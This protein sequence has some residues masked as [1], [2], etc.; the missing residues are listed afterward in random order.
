MN[1]DIEL[2]AHLMRRAGF[3]ASRTELEYRSSIGY[4]ATVEELLNPDTQLSSDRL[5][6]L[7]YHPH[8]WKPKHHQVWAGQVGY[9][10]W[11]APK[12]YYRRK[13]CYSGTKCS[14]LD[15]Q[16]STIIMKSYIR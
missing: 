13:W 15:T 16:K 10:T 3:G 1:N 2:I 6:F 11:L 14:L 7:R 12:E 9:M 5:E 8:F 4:D